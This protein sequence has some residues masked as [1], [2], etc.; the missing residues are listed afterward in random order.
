M[1]PSDLLPWGQRWQRTIP[2]VSFRSSTVSVL[3]SGFPEEAPS[4]WART[5]DKLIYADFCGMWE[6]SYGQLWLLDTP[7]C[8]LTFF[9]RMCCSL[10]LFNLILLPSHSPVTGVRLTLPSEGS[11][12]FL[13]HLSF[14]VHRFPLTP[15]I[16]CLFNPAL[17]PASQKTQNNTTLLQKF[18]YDQPDS[19]A[20]SLKWVMSQGFRH[21]PLVI[22]QKGEKKFISHFA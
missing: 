3:R 5:V 22:I 8:W 11:S 18:N 1:H 17:V 13:L 7:L 20:Q 12:N 4:Q 10:G 15:Q 19:C 2:A 16:S 21:V 6:N 9:F 14:F